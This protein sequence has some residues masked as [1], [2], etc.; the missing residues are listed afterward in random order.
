MTAMTRSRLVGLLLGAG[1]VLAACS[2][3]NGEGGADGSAD[4]GAT[5]EA[6]PPE[7]T[8]TLEDEVAF[9]VPVTIGAE[10]GTVA[11]AEVVTAGGGE[12]LDGAVEGSNWVSASPP[13]PGE[14][15]D[16]SAEVVDG[17]GETH[18]LTGSFSVAE[19]PDS[20][21]LTLSVVRGGGGRVGVGTPIIVRFDQEVTERAEVEAA[22]RVS[23]EPQVV[24]AWRWLSPTEVHFRPKE[25]WPANTQIRVDLELNGV[26][27]GENL[28]GGRAYSYDIEIG[29]EQRAVV[30][31]A[32]HTFSLIRNGEAVET[33][34]TSL[35]APEFATRNGTYIVLSKDEKYQMT[36]CN[37]NITCDENDPEYYDVDT[38]FA[39][40]LTNS[41]TFVHSAPWSETAQG[42]ENVSHGCLNLNEANAKA[43]YEAAQYGDIVEV[44]NSTREADDL[45]ER[46]DPGMVDWNLSW[47]EYLA[48]S[49]QGEFTTGQL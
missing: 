33:W 5:D 24:G 19:V 25:Y 37:A 29:A 17:G 27:A 34:N 9:D 13:L 47:Q 4:G 48:G 35:G 1:I 11:A 14:T 32:T 49:E 31:A 45:V 30:D 3:D 2:G 18:E 40:R 46:G 6:A 10:N 20:Q 26:R 28:W 41:G 21:R 23:S 16:V 38:E 7:P 8:L 42:E 44:R 22:M 15:Y 43:Y 36:S 12:P 39:V